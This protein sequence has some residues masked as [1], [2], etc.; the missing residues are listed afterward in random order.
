M[1]PRTIALRLVLLAAVLASSVLITLH[2]S[3]AGHRASPDRRSRRPDIH[4][5]PGLLSLFPNVPNI[6]KDYTQ[7]VEDG[8]P[9][10]NPCVDIASIPRTLTPIV[11]AGYE[12]PD[13]TTATIELAELLHSDAPL[14]VNAIRHQPP[15]CT[16][17]GYTKT[18]VGLEGG[19]QTRIDA[20]PMG[21]A[22]TEYRSTDLP[23]SMAE[24]RPIP[25]AMKTGGLRIAAVSG[26]WYIA[27]RAGEDKPENNADRLYDQALPTIF[28]A[29]NDRLG[30]A[31]HYQS[32]SAVDARCGRIADHLSSGRPIPGPLYASVIMVHDAACRS[33]YATITQTMSPSVQINDRTVDRTTAES[34]LRS[35]KGSLSA[36]RLTLESIGDDSTSGTVYY[37]YGKTTILISQAGAVLAYLTTGRS[38]AAFAARDNRLK[39]VDWTMVAKHD[40]KCPEF[41]LG[42]EASSEFPARAYDL[43][44]D[45]VADE[46]V[47]MDCRTGDGSSDDQIEVFDGTSPPSAPRRLGVLTA[48]GDGVRTRSISMSGRTVTI[49]GAIA[50]PDGPAGCPKISTTQR[51]TWNGV[52]FSFGTLKKTPVKGGDCA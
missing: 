15:E 39:A 20:P 50:T 41:T 4:T 2:L 1:T 48:I 28:A 47:D 46:I 26:D 29:L 14:L 12:A 18:E 52:T 42:P 43:T 51:I 17:T 21:D 24:R 6:K 31:F 40:L 3:S 34:L 37:R 33:E 13:G 9:E 22:S 5:T 35:S 16:L 7:I 25:P 10:W 36:I 11:Q 32:G 38:T 8:K 49:K 19:I 45:G 23:Y 44:G 27:T 30:T